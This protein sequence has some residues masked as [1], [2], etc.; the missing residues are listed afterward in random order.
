MLPKRNDFTDMTTVCKKSPQ[1]EF[2]EQ[3][4]IFICEVVEKEKKSQIFTF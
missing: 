1:R 2:N 4:E 3:L